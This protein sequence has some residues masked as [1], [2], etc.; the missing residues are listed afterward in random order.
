[1]SDLFVFRIKYMN[2]LA[3]QRCSLSSLSAGEPLLGTAIDRVSTWLLVEFSGAWGKKGIEDGGLPELARAR[4]LQAT[5]GRPWLRPQLIKRE[6]AAE[7][8]ASLRVVRAEKG[9]ETLPLS[10][11]D[12]VQDVDLAAWADGAAPDGVVRSVAPFV[13]V[14][15]HGKRDACCAEHGLALYRALRDRLGDDAVWQSTHLGGHRFAATFV[16]LPSGYQYGRARVEDADAIA[17]AFRTGEVGQPRLVRG[18]TTL[19]PAEQVADLAFRDASGVW[20]TQDGAAITSAQEPDGVV[21]VLARRPT[22]EVAE[23]RLRLVLGTEPLIG[24]C[25]AIETTVAR[26]F[27]TLPPDRNAVP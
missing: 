6:G 2:L 16:T 25:G 11:I 4:I 23:I 8:H 9:V 24:S 5:L 13:L 19:S 18:R 22:G 10:S 3:A 17:L 12:A 14:C 15:T 20:A 1:M 26:S 27:E 7:A 21:R